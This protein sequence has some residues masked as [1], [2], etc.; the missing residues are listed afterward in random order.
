M[1]H[2]TSKETKYKAVRF[3]VDPDGRDIADVVVFYDGPTPEEA[4][5][6]YDSRSEATVWKETL[7]KIA[8]EDSLPGVLPFCQSVATLY[9]K[10]FLP[11]PATLQ[12]RASLFLS[13]WDGTDD[14]IQKKTIHTTTATFRIPRHIKWAIRTICESELRGLEGVY[15]AAAV[16][17]HRQVVQKAVLQADNHNEP[18]SK[19]TRALLDQSAYVALLMGQGDLEAARGPPSKATR[20]RPVRNPAA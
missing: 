11:A 19:E 16:Q 7:Q 3:V 14:L 15:Q 20:P 9:Q 17:E 2:E 4:K 5:L 8:S 12:R 1:T 6:M 18:L 13:K 10:G